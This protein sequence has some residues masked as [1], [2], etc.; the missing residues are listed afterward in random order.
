[1]NNLFEQLNYAYLALIHG[2]QIKMSDVKQ[3]ITLQNSLYTRRFAPV[4]SPTIL[5]A[6]FAYLT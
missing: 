3:S 5:N 2:C 4:Q 6:T 1:M